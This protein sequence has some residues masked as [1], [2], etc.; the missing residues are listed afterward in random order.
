MKTRNHFKDD[1]FENLPCLK[2][3]VLHCDETTESDGYAEMNMLTNIF[4]H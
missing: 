2:T 4:I 3:V 1:I